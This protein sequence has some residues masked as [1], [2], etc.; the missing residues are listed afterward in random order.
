[1]MGFDMQFLMEHFAGDEPTDSHS[2]T[3]PNS[4]LSFKDYQTT[5]SREA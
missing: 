1:M 2:D 3:Q 5:L 4:Q